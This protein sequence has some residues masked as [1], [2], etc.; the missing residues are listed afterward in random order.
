MALLWVILP[1]FTRVCNL[2]MRQ[3]ILRRILFAVLLRFAKDLRLSHAAMLWS[4]VIL[5][6]V[7]TVEVRANSTATVLPVPSEDLTCSFLEQPLCRNAGYNQTAFPNPRQ[8]Q[9]QEEAASEM[10]DFS[11]LWTE[12]DPCSNALVYFLCSYYFPF[13]SMLGDSEERTTLLPCRSLCEAAR[14]GCESVIEENT[15]VGWPTFFECS[16][17]PEFG[18]ELLCY[19]PEDPST[20]ISPTGDLVTVASSTP[21]E[22][23]T[24]ATTTA[25]AVSSSLSLTIIYVLLLLTY[26]LQ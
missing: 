3:K 6:A 23:E 20:L 16:N 13:C 14:A 4:A 17:F 2:R 1:V 5:F 22:S 26:F 19:G 24:T 12:G 7:T 25:S 15:N 10:A 8:H 21:S 9:S 11:R 18:S